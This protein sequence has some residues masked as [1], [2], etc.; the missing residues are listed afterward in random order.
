M[1]K[2]FFLFIALLLNYS[3]FLYSNS[4]DSYY[5]LT[6]VDYTFS[7][8]FDMT[9]QDQPAGKVLKSAFNLI[10]EYE[11]Y[12]RFGLYEAKGSCRLVSL[13]VLFSWATIIDLYDIDNRPIGFIEGKFFTKEAAQF[14]FYNET[15]QIIGIAILHLENQQFKII[16]PIDGHVCATL[17]YE[18]T[19]QHPNLTVIYKT[20]KIPETFLKIFSAF[21]CDVQKNLIEID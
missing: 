3:Q 10:T 2:W 16:D 17:T 20:E 21:I 7:T 1:N 5:Q 12:N 11:L 13:G 18:K 9:W 15:K 14:N 6:K 4:R 19:S 8:I